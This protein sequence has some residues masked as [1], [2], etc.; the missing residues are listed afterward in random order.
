MNYACA[1]M[2]I[3]NFVLESLGGSLL[4][5]QQPRLLL[6][7]T[8]PTRL[9]RQLTQAQQKKADKAAAAMAKRKAATDAGRENVAGA[10]ATERGTRRRV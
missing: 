2:K 5:L 4:R 1:A 6:A 7:I 9:C 3:L 8:L 10:P